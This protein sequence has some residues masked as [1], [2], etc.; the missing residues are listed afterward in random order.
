MDKDSVKRLKTF[1]KELWP[2]YSREIFSNLYYTYHPSGGNYALNP[3]SEF[4]DVAWSKVE[5]A[6]EDGRRLGLIDDEDHNAPRFND[7]FADEEIVQSWLEALL[8]YDVLRNIMDDFRHYRGEM[9]IDET[10]KGKYLDD[11]LRHDWY[12][13]HNFVKQLESTDSPNESWNIPVSEF[14]DLT[15]I[16]LIEQENEYEEKNNLSEHYNN[17]WKKEGRFLNEDEINNKPM[18]LRRYLDNTHSTQIQKL[19][20]ESTK[21]KVLNLFEEI[22]TDLTELGVIEID[23]NMMIGGL[24]TN[25]IVRQWVLE[26]IDPDKNENLNPGLNPS[27]VEGDVIELIY[28]D[29]PWNPIPVATKG[30]VMGFEKVP[31]GEDKILVTWVMGPDKMTNMPMI[32][33]VDVWRKIVPEK[34][35]NHEPKEDYFTGSKFGD[36][37]G[38]E[39]DVE[40]IYEYVKSNGDKYLKKNISIDSK[41]E[42]NFKW[43]ED[44]YDINNPEHKERMMNSDTSFPIL[45]VIEKDGNWAVSDG[46]NRLYKA[47]HVE[48]K[49]TI[50]GYVI[51]KEEILDQHIGQLKENK[52]L[53][54][55]EVTQEIKY[56]K[57]ADS[58]FQGRNYIFFNN[59]SVSYKDPEAQTM[60]FDGPNGRLV[61]DSIHVALTK[62]GKAFY[63]VYDEDTRDLLDPLLTFKEERDGPCDFSGW[64]L[65]KDRWRNSTWRYRLRDTIQNTLNQMYNEYKS[66]DGLPTEYHIKN[67]FVNVPGT[68]ADGTSYGWSILNFFLTNE[69]V[70]DIL[71]KAYEK[72]LNDNNLSCYFDIGE[73]TE[74]IDL[75]QEV[76]F[77]LD[78][79]LFKEMVR[80][81]K[82][83]WKGGQ[84]TETIIAPRLEELFGG[85]WKAVYDGEPGII[86]DVL[87]GV[88]IK[89]VNAN[90]G[91]ELTFQA[92]PLSGVEERE[93]PTGPEW[94]VRSH[95][96]KHYPSKS[97]SHYVFGVYQGEIYVFK[98][99]DAEIKD[100]NG[101]EYMVFNH[102]P[103]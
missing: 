6:V 57:M 24:T 56:G 66:P 78:Q 30:V 42:H 22:N 1:F 39:F 92:K 65:A 34:D 101:Q 74:W 32:P 59:T 100:V 53:L 46:L 31:H 95:G 51:S 28:M 94:W 48:G 36:D 73:F 8:M 18:E 38:N 88:D 102:P 84:K 81:N 9:G 10:G 55:E 90:N 43:W 67:G 76:L 15:D 77:G 58:N 68:D 50:D 17:W 64:V 41:L 99:Q 62:T 54:K 75:N 4:S 96:L 12:A 27:L 61:I 40:S 13:L 21:D 47:K 87:K 97:V 37:E 44:K 85:E 35:I 72:H 82:A 60:I 5:E 2:T 98:N 91:K 19:Q 83:G 20:L 45:V 49:D 29:D 16:E 93:G 33:E 70:R 25:P 63:V 89:L 14:V 11:D 80:R 3:M 7:T 23:S 86:G 79:P 103:L 71:V 69:H 52:T 26:N